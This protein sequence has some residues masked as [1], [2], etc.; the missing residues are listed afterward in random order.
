MWRKINS[1]IKKKK[2][3]C[4]PPPVQKKNAVFSEKLIN[5]TDPLVLNLFRPNKPTIPYAYDHIKKKHKKND[6]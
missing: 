4:S 3:I 2:L 5:K 6:K 1:I